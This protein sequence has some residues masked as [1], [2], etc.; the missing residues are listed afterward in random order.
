MTILIAG[1][2]YSGKTFLAKAIYESTSSE[3]VVLDGATMDDVLDGRKLVQLFPKN[4]TLIVVVQSEQASFNSV[5][6]DVFDQIIIT[7]K[8]LDI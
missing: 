3:T 1:P 4:K 8:K 7:P 2:Q 5:L 6:Y